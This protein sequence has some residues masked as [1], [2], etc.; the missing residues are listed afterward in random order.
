MCVYREDKAATEAD[1]LT[2]V[3]MIF[4]RGLA[5]AALR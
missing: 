2:N 1:T 3:R 5:G 4:E